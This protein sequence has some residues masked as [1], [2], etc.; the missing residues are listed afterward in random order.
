MVD[1][2]SRDPGEYKT[3]LQLVTVLSHGKRASLY[4]LDRVVPDLSTEAKRLTDKAVNQMEGVQNLR[5]AVYEYVLFRVPSIYAEPISFKL[6][7]EAAEKGS[8]KYKTLF[9]QGV[10]YLYRCE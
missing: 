8:S 3:I 7:A 2:R 6:K 10:N 1:T 5:K 4:L 9:Q